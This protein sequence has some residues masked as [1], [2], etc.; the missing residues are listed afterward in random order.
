M[1][2]VNP[3]CP[4]CG[5]AKDRA[6]FYVDRKRSNGL[7]T[8]CKSCCKERAKERYAADPA[9][10]KRRHQAWVERNRERVKLHRIKAE[11][12]LSPEEYDAIPKVCVI[13]GARDDL[14]VDHSHRTGRVRGM[15]CDPCNKG[16]GF[17]RDDPTLLL[18]AA[19]Y[20][21]GVAKPDIFAATY[22]AIEL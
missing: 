4:A 22:E 10:H 21:F 14:R 18:R 17:L 20:V 3:V 8:Y 13:C 16:L 12:G 5:E 7:H 11:Y 2:K 19:D 1:T 9:G 15:L 6:E